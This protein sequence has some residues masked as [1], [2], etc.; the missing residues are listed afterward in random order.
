MKRIAIIILTVLVMA[1]PLVCSAKGWGPKIFHDVPE[2]ILLTDLPFTAHFTAVNKEVAYYAVQC[3]WVSETTYVPN[4]V[5]SQE[6]SV[7][8]DFKKPNGNLL[9]I[10]VAAADP[11]GNITFLSVDITL[12]TDCPGCDFSCKELNTSGNY[13]C[14]TYFGIDFSGADLSWANLRGQH[15]AE[16][17]FTGAT[18]IGTDFSS[19]LEAEHK[20]VTALHGAKF[21]G[22]NLTD[23]NFENG[24]V[25][26]VEWDNCV[27]P[28]GSLA[29]DHGQTCIGYGVEEPPP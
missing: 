2:I 9:E 4:G 6:F 19:D 18:L 22:A 23:A 28:D 20:I 17:N 16:A 29:A 24:L 10:L 5:Q 12:N 3:N 25:Y 14:D 11:A 21:I 27:C 15:L 8:M 7:P 1:F 26:Y 13:D